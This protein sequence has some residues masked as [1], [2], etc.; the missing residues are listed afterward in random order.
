M[1]GQKVLYKIGGDIMDT[2]EAH[3]VKKKRACGAETFESC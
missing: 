3:E 2:S 1:G